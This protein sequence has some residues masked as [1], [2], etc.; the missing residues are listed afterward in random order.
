MSTF[1]D[2]LFEM[3]RQTRDLEAGLEQ[4]RE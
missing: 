3:E 2:A 1:A 4:V